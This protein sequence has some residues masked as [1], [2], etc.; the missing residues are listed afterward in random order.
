MRTLP[1]V[2]FLSIF[3]LFSVLA[4]PS[5]QGMQN[6]D[7]AVVGTW[8]LQ[9]QDV[10]R[11]DTGEVDTFQ[12]TDKSV[13]WLMYDASGRMA[14]QIDRRGWEPRSF[15]VAYFGKY[16]IDVK[17]GVVV[18]HVQSGTV[19]SYLDTDQKRGFEVRDGGQ[20]LVITVERPGYDREQW[21]GAPM[22]RRLTWKRLH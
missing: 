10:R 8:Q 21:P 18:H 19:D 3:G 11:A 17:S 1:F 2:V 14:V 7:I 13:G 6:A 9:S 20:T 22:I 15:Y 5:P 12:T 4:S 16:S